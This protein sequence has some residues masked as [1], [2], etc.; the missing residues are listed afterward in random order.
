MSPSPELP[1]NVIIGC[2]NVMSNAAGDFLLVKE[3]KPSARSRFN[4]PAGK[5]DVGETLTDA[6]IREAKEETGLDVAVDHLIGIYQCP[7]TSEGFGVVNF[8][9]ASRVTGGEITETPA[10]PVVRYFPRAEIA[11]LAARGLIRGTHIEL[12]IDDHGAG[13]RLPL[14]VVQV[15]PPSPLPPT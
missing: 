9:F 1:A 3:A 6:T 14:D 4:F 2:C 11:T 7:R 10:H 8:V 15:V 12:A 5:P 13:Q